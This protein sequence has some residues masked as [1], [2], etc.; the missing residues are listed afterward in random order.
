MRTIA[1]W[2]LPFTP[3]ISAQA[4]QGTDSREPAGHALKH[5]ACGHGRIAPSATLAA[6]RVSPLASSPLASHVPAGLPAV[7]RVS[8]LAVPMQHSR[9]AER[10]MPYA[11]AHG[12]AAASCAVDAAVTVATFAIS[13]PPPFNR[14]SSTSRAFTPGFQTVG[15]RCSD[16]TT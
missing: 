6:Y 5:C 4:P 15:C 16:V 10:E 11:G 3:S 8:P 12:I 7:H 9:R 2:R 1:F 13:A 14:A